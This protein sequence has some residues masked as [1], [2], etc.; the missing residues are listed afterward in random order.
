MH[1]SLV[2]RHSENKRGSNVV[3]GSSLQV[4]WLL[5]HRLTCC[6]YSPLGN[7]LCVLEELRLG[8]SGVSKQQHVDVATQAVAA[9]GVLLLAAKQGEGN[10]TLDVQVAVDGGCNGVED[11]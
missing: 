2:K 3:W 10:A 4:S 8:G 7:L 1:Q 5:S 11:Q 6:V 9:G